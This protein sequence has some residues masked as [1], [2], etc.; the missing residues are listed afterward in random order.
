[1]KYHTAAISDIAKSF[2]GSETRGLTESQ[3][4]EN[5]KKYG[6]NK[7]S[8]TK[9]RGFF[10]RLF[11]ALTEPTLIILEFAWVITVGINV[12]KFLK[13]GVCDVYECIGIFIAIFLSVALTMFMEGRSEKAFE[14][15]GATYDRL[16]VKVIRGGEVKV[17]PKEEIVAGDLILLE[18]GDKIIADGRLIDSVGLCVDEST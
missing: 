13:S 3:A 16:S 12:G 2:N 18:T 14:L 10:A 4:V 6:E 8:K 7:M 15:L 9:K 5:R 1:M 11:S 17:V